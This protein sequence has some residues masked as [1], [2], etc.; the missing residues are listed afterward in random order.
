MKKKK[1]D[2]LAKILAHELNHYRD[3]PMKIE[4]QIDWSEYDKEV[5]DKFKKMFLNLI[6]NRENIRLEMNDNLISVST[7]D[8]TSLKKAHKKITLSSDENYLRL[9]VTKQGFQINRGYRQRTNFKDE[10]IYD[11]LIKDVKESQKKYNSEVF[12]QVWTEIMKDS[13]IVR[14]H[15]LDELFNG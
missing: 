4:E 5:S 14:D 3:T 7:D 1:I 10:N 12:N 6:S 11:E 13:G 8:L 15:N 9:D 2:K